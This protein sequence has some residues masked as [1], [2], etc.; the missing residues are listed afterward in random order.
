MMWNDAAL[1]AGREKN[2]PPRLIEA[3][4]LARLASPAQGPGGRPVQLPAFASSAS[5]T[6]AGFLSL[7][8]SLS[9]FQKR[10]SRGIAELELP[11]GP[12]STSLGEEVD[13]QAVLRH[14]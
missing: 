6:K 4:L 11:C 14:A 13:L 3:V 2:T 9:L 12:N 5:G 1:A 8:L 10:V 7:S